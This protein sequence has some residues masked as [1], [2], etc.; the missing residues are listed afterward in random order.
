MKKVASGCRYSIFND[1][2]YT[3]K[4][5]LRKCIGHGVR[6]KKKQERS[7]EAVFDFAPEVLGHNA[8]LN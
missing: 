1:G 5:R 6:H 7:I 8:L 4:Y 3:L 2:K